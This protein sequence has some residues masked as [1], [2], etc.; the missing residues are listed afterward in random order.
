MA[1]ENTMR[2]ARNT[3]FMYSRM[4]VSM[5][6]TLFTSRI[7]L[8]QLG[9]TDFGVYNVVA[10]LIVVFSFVSGSFASAS[11]R[12]ISFAIGEDNLE[13]IKSIFSSLIFINV[14]LAALVIILAET[15]GLWYVLNMLNYPI[16]LG[17]TVM[18]IYQISII[19]TVFGILAIPFTSM[20]IGQEKMDIY[21]YLSIFDVV[22]KL[23]VA[24]SLIYLEN[25]LIYYAAMQCII[26]LLLLAIYVFYCYNNGYLPSISIKPDFSKVK[27]I[28]CFSSWTLYSGVCNVAS[29]QGVNLLLNFVYGVILNTAY[30]LTMQVQNAI[31]SFSLG[32]QIALNPQLIKTYS[33]GDMT[34]HRALIFR[35]VKFSFFLVLIVACPIY[36]NVEPLLNLWL[37]QYP[38]Q[39]ISFIK[40]IVLA[41]IVTT[42]ANP[43]GVSVEASGKIGRMT[44]IAYTITLLSLP[45]SWIL[46]KFINNPSIPFIVLFVAQIISLFVRLYFAQKV[47]SFQISTL[48]RHAILPC[49][50]VG[51]TTFVICFLLCNYITGNSIT[52]LSLRIFIGIA[53]PAVLSY[54]LGMSTNE[55]QLLRNL[56]VK[57]LHLK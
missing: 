22:A 34:G 52:I 55:Q 3:L 21:A 38:E 29:T 25:K 16:E 8:Q 39:T 53:V 48:I 45:F 46:L 36:F 28:L 51:I 15:I 9:E 18:I 57:K 20:I 32:F 42:I 37:G 13:S 4:I 17:T 30:G 50:W 2:L 54:Y 14:G 11:S 5:F 12:F 43:F 27:E 26:A 49:I 7:V 10:G 56:L 35:S 24:I 33:S 47:A 40:W 19:T 41:T 1:S 31:R 44:F 6:I 23:A